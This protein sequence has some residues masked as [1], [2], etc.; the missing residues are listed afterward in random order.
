MAPVRLLRVELSLMAVSLLVFA[1]APLLR[2]SKP[3]NDNFANR[4]VLVG[5]TNTV[6]AS[7]GG[8]TVEPGEPQHAGELG[9]RSV[10]WSWTAPTTGTYAASTSGSG[11]DTLLAVYIGSSLTNLK[12]V[13]SNDDFNGEPISEVFFRAITGET[14]QLAVDGFQGTNGTIIL[15]LNPSGTA[16]TPWTLAS[17]SSNRPISSVLFRNKVVL[18]DF[19]GTTCGD[20][21]YEAPFLHDLRARHLVDGFDIVAVA[22]DTNTTPSQIRYN[23]DQ[24]GIDYTLVLNNAQVEATY[25][26]PLPMPTKVL[27]DREGKIQLRITGSQ[28]L[29]YYESVVGPLIRGASN[30]RVNIHAQTNR[31]VL[32]WPNTEFGYSVEAATNLAPNA[33]TEVSAP[34]IE[35]DNQ[36][37][38]S[39]ATG[40]G[41]MFFRLR[42]P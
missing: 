39:V 35:V 13:A 16:Q 17:V 3:P 1:G 2:A 14:Y 6:T 31:V 32:S 28:T 11:F 18:M 26:G 37:T 38:A 30:L 15:N 9:G 36:N 7:N 27:V 21:I 41:A 34:I 5:P 29:D 4:T 20:C 8:A 33:W 23:A 12:E 40:G 19:F 22:K 25:G 42:K 10:W 24:M